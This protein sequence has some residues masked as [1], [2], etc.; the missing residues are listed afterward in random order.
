MTGDASSLVLVVQIEE[1][2]SEQHH[3][4]DH[5]LPI[6]VDADKVQ[7]RLT[8]GVLTLTLPK[9]ESAKPKKIKVE[10]A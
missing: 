8:H 3:A 6:D 2:R 5:L 10:A 1:H 7:A 9:S 4:L